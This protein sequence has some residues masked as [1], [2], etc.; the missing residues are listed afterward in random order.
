MLRNLCLTAI[1]LLLALNLNAQVI[2]TQQY[3]GFVGFNDT[4]TIDTITVTFQRIGNDHY[5][6]I[7]THFFTL[8]L[9]P[10]S[11]VDSL[12]FNTPIH[13]PV[14]HFK[15]TEIYQNVTH[16]ADFQIYNNKFSGYFLVGNPSINQYN[17]IRIA[18]FQ[19]P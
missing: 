18:T 9:K 5:L 13:S 16:Y 19:Y 17:Y 14:I 1:I 7:Q 8:H 11:Y 4:K 15:L 12:D 3:A 6:D 10:Y 2:Y